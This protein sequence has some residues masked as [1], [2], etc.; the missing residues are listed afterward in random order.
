[1]RDRILSKGPERPDP[2]PS[3]MNRRWLTLLWIL[4]T[5][6]VLADECWLCRRV[7]PPNPLSSVVYTEAR[8][9]QHKVCQF[10]LKDKEPCSI[11][12]G[13][14]NAKPERDGRSICPDCKKVAIDTPQEAESLYL[15]VQ[16]FVQTLTLGLKVDKAPPIMLVEADEMDTRW[17]ETSGRS[18]QAHAFYRAYNPE[19]I[20][21]LSGHS[22]FDLG[23]T[24][25]H[26]FTHAWQ[27]RF[28][29]SQ[30]RMVTEGFAT[31]VEYK[32]A[33]SKGY[34]DHLAALR[35]LREPDYAEGLAKCLEMEKRLGAK[36][37]VEWMRKNTKF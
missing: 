15:E 36:G 2:K 13:P 27:S 20:Y 1:M 6:P 37:L 16:R 21:A 12:R 14:T 25:A 29:P 10:C 35:S 23:P 8:T 24:L 19:M 28:C 34:S 11:C 22:P 3:V 31:W 4:L 17:V 9:V 18:M 5:A 7:D 26:E 33:Q 30:D 32:Y